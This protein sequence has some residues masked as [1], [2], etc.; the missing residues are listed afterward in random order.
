[1]TKLEM[2]QNIR[3]AVKLYHKTFKIGERNELFIEADW[4]LY[5]NQDSTLVSSMTKE[6]LK[7]WMGSLS[8]AFQKQIAG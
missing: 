1:M 4:K 7:I 2:V 6:E 5:K 3:S 8:V